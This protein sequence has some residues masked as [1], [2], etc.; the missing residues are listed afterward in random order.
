[1]LK[2]VSEFNGT[3]LLYHYISFIKRGTKYGLA[4]GVRAFEP[5]KYFEIS[6]HHSPLQL[7]A[8][9]KFLRLR[10]RPI[11]TLLCRDWNDGNGMSHKKYGMAF[12]TC[13]PDPIVSYDL[14]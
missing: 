11:H 7:S 12:F 6:T 4:A 1:M 3:F 10:H 13:W 2:P 9:A 8:P 14:Y 5:L